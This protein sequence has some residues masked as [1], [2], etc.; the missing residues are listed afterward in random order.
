MRPVTVRAIVL[1][2]ALGALAAGAV[3]SAAGAA[4]EPQ[5]SGGAIDASDRFVATWV[6]AP[7]TSFQSLEFSSTPIPNPMLPA[8]FAGR[9]LVDSFCAPPPA[10]SCS[11]PPTLT[12]YRATDRVARD[13]RYYFK[14][15]ARDSKGRTRTS[16][17]W[18]LDPGKPLRPGGGK[19]SEVPT[20]TPVLAQPY[21][22]PRRRTIPMPRLILP[23]PPQT[24]TG[25]LRYGVRARVIC[26]KVA[27]YALVGMSLGK[28]ALVFSDTTIRPGGRDTFA[29]R[30]RPSRRA[31]LARRKRAK[32][33]IRAEIIQPGG[34]TTSLAK[35]VRIRR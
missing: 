27:C 5:I 3:P 11:A 35:S 17:V 12:V 28:T 21:I 18:V 2:L 16:P 7:E 22:A 25:V 30:P 20:N 6:L 1:L 31:R 13:R 4:G 10:A 26:P 14:V 15:N 9:N 19:P 8:S 32:L 34:K 24:I 33:T 23:A 29:L